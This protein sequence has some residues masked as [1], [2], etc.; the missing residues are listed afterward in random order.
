MILPDGAMLGTETGVTLVYL[1]L[2]LNH[3]NGNTQIT[4]ECGEDGEWTNIEAACQYGKNICRLQSIC[5]ERE[6]ERER[7]RESTI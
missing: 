6:R 4:S 1:C 7:E 3:M 5:L 2:F